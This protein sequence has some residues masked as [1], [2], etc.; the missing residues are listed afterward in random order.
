MGKTIG[1]S[2]LVYLLSFYKLSKQ[3]LDKLYLPALQVRTP[4]KVVTRPSELL[5]LREG[6]PARLVSELIMI[7]IITMMIIFIRCVRPPRATPSHHWPGH[8]RS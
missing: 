8:T 2:D 1:I 7:I 3:N 5:V 4:P 6:S